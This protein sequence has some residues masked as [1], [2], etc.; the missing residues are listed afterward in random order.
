MHINI[1]DFGLAVLPLVAA[2]VLIRHFV[3][4]WVMEDE[5]RG[6]HIVGGLLMIGTWWIF[7]LGF[8]YT[9]FN[10]KVP[11]VPTPKDGNEDNNWPLN[12]P[13]LAILAFSVTAIVYGLYTD[14]NPYN[15]I[16]ACFAGMN[17]LFMCFNIAASRQQ[18]FRILRTHH[19]WLNVLMIWVKLLKGY[20]WIVRRHI[21]SGVRTSALSLVVFLICSLI[22]VTRFR[23][24]DA[25]S[26]YQAIKNEAR[27]K[28]AKAGNAATDFLKLSS[29]V[30]N[31]FCG[32]GYCGR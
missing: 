32:F 5:E 10:K 30:R 9:I 2:I 15:I 31:T 24:G 8:V 25:D 3:Q 18:Q 27:A 23:S 7:I 28:K 20:F 4:W 11:Y 19:H 22:Y 1:E 13:N 14:W 17:C 26:I 16:M 21:Y 6:F 12:I 29:C